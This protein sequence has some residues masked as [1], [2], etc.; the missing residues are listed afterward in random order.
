MSH[1]EENNW[2]LMLAR[3]NFG[4]QESGSAVDGVNLI[5]IVHKE[6]LSRKTPLKCDDPPI[7]SQSFSG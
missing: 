5:G 3:K 1:T 6:P 7:I 2:H 4:R